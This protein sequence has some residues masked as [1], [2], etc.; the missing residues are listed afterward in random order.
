M[1]LP[2]LAEPVLTPDMGRGPSRYPISVRNCALRLRPTS[3]SLSVSCRV[4]SDDLFDSVVGVFDRLGLSQ[5]RRKILGIPIASGQDVPDDDE[6]TAFVST[7]TRWAVYSIA[8][9]GSL[10]GVIERSLFNKDFREP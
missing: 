8:D 1:V 5:L 10:P 7:R 3:S 9:S 2:D 4:R 6:G